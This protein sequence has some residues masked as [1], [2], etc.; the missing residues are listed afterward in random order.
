M[1]VAFRSVCLAAFLG[2]L[3][4]AGYSQDKPVDPPPGNPQVKPAEVPAASPASPG[5]T[6]ASNMAPGPVSDPAKTTEAPKVETDPARMAQPVQP[7]PATPDPS[8][9][10]GAEDVLGISVWSD[11][12]LSGTFLVRPDGRISIPLSGEVMA[13]GKT[14]LAL[15]TAIRDALIEKGILKHPQVTVQVNQINSKK[16]FLQ[17]EVNKT[18]SFPLVVPTTVLEA[19]V[20]AG[21]FRD[22]ANSR[23][24]EV[25]RKDGHRYRFNYNDVIKGKHTEQN[26][27][28]MPG[29]I[30]IVP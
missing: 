5:G 11:P 24:I 13:T 16:Y 4:A 3:C 10:I 30:I 29:D 28:L 26:I 21:G 15:E 1:K 2:I 6:P 17:G 8:Y 27:N 9:V 12:R 7:P 18:G 25:I 22:F 19:L 23:K 14:P 20:N